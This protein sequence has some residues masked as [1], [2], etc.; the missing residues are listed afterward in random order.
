M[1]MIF[2]MTC[3]ELPKCDWYNQTSPYYR[4]PHHTQR[5]LIMALVSILFRSQSTKE[6]FA[7]YLTILNNSKI[8]ESY[9]CVG[10]TYKVFLLS[11]LA[12]CSSKN[13]TSLQNMG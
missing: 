11:L 7:Q 6:D 8:R 4:P 2:V 12:L 3:Y 5:Q 9:W 10:R 1:V 13:S